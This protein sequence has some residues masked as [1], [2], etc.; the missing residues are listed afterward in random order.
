M[1]LK[2]SVPCGTSCMCVQCRNTLDDVT[3]AAMGWSIPGSQQP[4]NAAAAAAARDLNASKKSGNNH[5]YNAVTAV[6]GVAELAAAAAALLTSSSSCSS[7]AFDRTVDGNRQV[8]M[9]VV[10]L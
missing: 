4:I 10:Q 7:A 3:N 1:I 5:T 2:A 6:T 8:G 9:I